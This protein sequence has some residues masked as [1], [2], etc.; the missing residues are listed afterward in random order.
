MQR[1]GFGSNLGGWWSARVLEAAWG[2][3]PVLVALGCGAEV[4]DAPPLFE[5]AEPVAGRPTDSEVRT[6][7]SAE[8]ASPQ[9]AFEKARQYAAAAKWRSFCRYLT[10][11]AQRTLAVSLMV[12]GDRLVQRASRAAH[13][14]RTPEGLGPAA[15]ATSKRVR[16]VLK[17]HGIP[18]NV[19]LHLPPHQLETLARNHSPL[20]SDIMEPLAALVEDPPGFAAEMLEALQGTAGGVERRIGL[21]GRLEDVQIDGTRATAVVV[22]RDEVGIEKRRRIAFRRIGGQ[23]RIAFRCP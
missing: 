20:T 19:L 9:V 13:A 4:P 23:W 10:P 15:V 2:I 18:D 14:G 22:T 12:I 17:R 8:A 11:E 6:T 7:A 5:T 16:A 21:E 1:T 3:V